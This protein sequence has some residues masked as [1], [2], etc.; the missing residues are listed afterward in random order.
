MS[1]KDEALASSVTHT[2][3][4]DKRI[5]G[6]AIAVRTSDGEVFLKGR[7]DTEKHKELAVLVAQGV[8]GVKYVRVH[9]LVISEE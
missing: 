5:G 8:L 2:L 3:A 9:E 4:Q 1:I 7:V 6:Q